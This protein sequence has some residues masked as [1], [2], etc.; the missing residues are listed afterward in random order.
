MLA[1]YLIAMLGIAAL[2][3]AWLAVQLAWGRSFSGDG[4]DP[5]VLAARRG[6][7]GCAR[8]DRCEPAPPRGEGRQPRRIDHE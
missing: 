6:C 7:G 8:E 3:A 1:S 2:A 4:D 5:D